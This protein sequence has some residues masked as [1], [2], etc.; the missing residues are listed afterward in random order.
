MSS[1]NLPCINIDDV[2]DDF[3]GTYKDLTELVLAMV[4]L[5][6]LKAYRVRNNEGKLQC[7]T[8]KVIE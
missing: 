7:Y 3:C 2:T 8:F 4:E 6:G 1:S 5:S